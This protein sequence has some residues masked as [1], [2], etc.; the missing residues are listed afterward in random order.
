MIM[1][2]FSTLLNKKLFEHFNLSKDRV[3]NAVLK[4][5]SS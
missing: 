2:C 3:L 1:K 4:E 5:H